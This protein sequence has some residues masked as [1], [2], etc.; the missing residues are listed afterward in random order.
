MLALNPRGEVPAMKMGNVVVND[1]LAACDYIEVLGLWFI[2]ILLNTYMTAFLQF[3]ITK[4][5]IYELGFLSLVFVTAGG[6][7]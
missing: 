5:Y 7:H 1:S 6:Y 2:R 4:L 3:I